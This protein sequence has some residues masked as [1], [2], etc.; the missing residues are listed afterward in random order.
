VSYGEL[1]RALIARALVND[2][3]LLLLDEPCT[4]LDVSAR[5]EM[6]THLE[7]VAQAGV[8]I[9]LATHHVQDFIPSIGRVARLARGRLVVER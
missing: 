1:R 4:G 8:Q 5:A 9:I 2:P 7:N 3:W 6:L